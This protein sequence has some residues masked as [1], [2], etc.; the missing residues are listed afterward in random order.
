MGYIKILEK[1]D[2]MTS[3]YLLNKNNKYLLKGYFYKM[4]LKGGDNYG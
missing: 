4:F 1:G 3:F 2:E